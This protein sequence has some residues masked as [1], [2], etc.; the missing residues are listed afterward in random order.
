MQLRDDLTV[1]GLLRETASRFPDRPAIQTRSLTLTY[2]QLDEAV[3][4]AARRLL[5]IWQEEVIPV[6]RNP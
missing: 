4:T 5:F 6:G 1:G 3:D 2:R